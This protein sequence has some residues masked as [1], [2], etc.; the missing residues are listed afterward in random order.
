[1]LNT[2]RFI[3]ELRELRGL[4]RNGGEFFSLIVDRA[5]LIAN[6]FLSN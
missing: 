6:L 5:R 2:F 3:H 4:R 1:M